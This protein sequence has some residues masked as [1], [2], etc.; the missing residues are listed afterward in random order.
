MKPTDSIETIRYF[1]FH[2]SNGKFNFQNDGIVLTLESWSTPT[3]FILLRVVDEDDE[4]ERHPERKMW[5]IKRPRWG[6]ATFTVDDWTGCILS[7]L[8]S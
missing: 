6:L 4:I 8:V 2:A 1:R 3:P 7:V 5:I